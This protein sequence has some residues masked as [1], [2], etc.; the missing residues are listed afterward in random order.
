MNRAAAKHDSMK[1]EGVRWV[2]FTEASREPGV[3]Q[4]GVVNAIRMG[5]ASLI[6]TPQPMRLRLCIPVGPNDDY[7]GPL[8]RRKDRGPEYTNKA[9][10][11][12]PLGQYPNHS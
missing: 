6:M 7:R 3:D 2:Q 1:Y 11:T 4:R 9:S 10:S 12:Q 8:N 5:A